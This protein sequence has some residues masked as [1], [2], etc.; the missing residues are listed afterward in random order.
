MTEKVTGTVAVAVASCSVMAVQ[1]NE[2]FHRH[3]AFVSFIIVHILVRD[4]A[5]LESFLKI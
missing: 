4:R 1:V 2:R 3:S 5:K